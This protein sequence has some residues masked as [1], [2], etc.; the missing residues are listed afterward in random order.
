MQWVMAER[1]LVEQ[2]IEGQTVVYI[3]TSFFLLQYKYT[4]DFEGANFT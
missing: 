4:L 1:V 3:W 2:R